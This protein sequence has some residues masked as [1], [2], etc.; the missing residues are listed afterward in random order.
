MRKACA[1][2][3]LFAAS[4]AGPAHGDIYVYVDEQGVTHITNQ[5]DTDGRWQRYLE[6]EDP[7]TRRPREGVVP[8][9]ARDTSPDRYARYDAYILEASLLYQMP[10]ALIRAVIRV[11]SDYDPNVVS[12]AGAQGLMQL[13]PDTASRMEV[14]DSFDP[15]QNILGGTR[16]LRYLANL[17]QGDL[18]LTIAGYHAGEG[19]VLRYQGVPPYTTTHGY[20]RRVVEHYYRYL[21]ASGS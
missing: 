15:R 7:E 2:I 16:Y 6:T 11:E 12:W 13:M 10:E 4:L 9:P 18:V 3:V 1:A 17:F 19:A 5:P 14:T 21:Q 20:I 8:V